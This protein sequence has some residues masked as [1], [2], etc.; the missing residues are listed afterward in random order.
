MDL[1]IVATLYRSESHLR[2]FHARVSREAQRHGTDYEL[3]LV[4]DGSPDASLALALEIARSDP[5][6]TVIDLSRN[7]GH[8]KAIMTGLAHSRGERVFLID[9]D[10][11]EEPELLS[12]FSEE[13]AAAKVDVV[14]G[15]QDTRKGGAFERWSGRLFFWLFNL[16]S[17]DPLPVNLCTVRL[18]TRRYVDALIAHRERAMIIGGLW[19]ITGFAQLALPIKKGTRPGSSY[20][21]GRK[22]SILVNAVTSFS[23]KPL[24]FIFYLGLLLSLLSFGAAFLLVM[25]RVFFGVLLAGWPS[26]MVSVGFLGGLTLFCLGVIGIYLQKV[27]IETKQRPYTIVRA[28][29]GPGS[30]PD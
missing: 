6:V 22:V 9:C 19:V 30:R 1:S 8:H 20:G 17:D 24:L 18:M 2:E 3:I 21:L 7:F 15:V 5:R 14:F 12:R 29:H 25:R 23:A 27:F 26:L 13:M 10:L 4:N 11:E 16:L 28:I